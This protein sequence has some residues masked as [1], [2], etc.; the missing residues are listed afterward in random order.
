MDSTTT[1]MNE[2]SD[3]WTFSMVSFDHSL[4][5]AIEYVNGIL[6]SLCFCLEFRF[7]R[8]QGQLP[9]QKPMAYLVPSS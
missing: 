4:V 5:L 9:L 8:P 3:T 1:T 2:E 7:E 6:T